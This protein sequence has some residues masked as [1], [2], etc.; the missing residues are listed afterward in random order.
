MEEILIQ[1]DFKTIPWLQQNYQT[2]IGRYSEKTP[3]HALMIYGKA[4]IGKVRLTDALIAGILCRDLHS[5]MPCGECQSCRWLAT[6]FHP[7][8]YE[9]KGES[10]S[11]IHI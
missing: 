9:I 6:H 10:L 5:N 3:P 7:D 11:L 2:L 1:P 4:G 8:L